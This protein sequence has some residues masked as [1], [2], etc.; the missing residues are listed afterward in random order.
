MGCVANLQ[1]TS[2]D[3]ALLGSLDVIRSV[4]MREWNI[5]ILSSLCFAFDLIPRCL[6]DERAFSPVLLTSV[7]PPSLFLAGR[8]AFLASMLAMGKRQEA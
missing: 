1:L 3:D 8:V 5:L 2:V 4:Q 7:I 6:E